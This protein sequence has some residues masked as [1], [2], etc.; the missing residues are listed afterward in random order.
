MPLRAGRRLPRAASITEVLA[1]RRRRA[2]PSPTSGSSRSTS[3]WL[4]SSAPNYS[5]RSH[6]L[7]LFRAT[8]P[9]QLARRTPRALPKLLHRRGVSQHAACRSRAAPGARPSSSTM[10]QSI[11]K[12][13]RPC[14]SRTASTPTP[15]TSSPGFPD[16]AGNSSAR[17]HQMYHELHLRPARDQLRRLARRSQ[18]PRGH[19]TP[20]TTLGDSSA[21]AICRTIDL[22]GSGLVTT[23]P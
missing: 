18:R 2:A 1:P 17:C 11:R 9:H 7:V 5:T 22:A 13:A 4:A 15:A 3:R 14:P 10:Q 21:T 8:T 20:T 12:G 6:A 16:G 23:T 19:R